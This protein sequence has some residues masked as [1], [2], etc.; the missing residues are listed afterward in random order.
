M[1]NLTIKDLSEK[2][3]AKEVSCFEVTQHF[4][5]RIKNLDKKINSFITVTEEIALNKAKELDNNFNI[6]SQNPLAGIPI[7]HKDLFATKGILTTSGSK[8][9]ANY[10]APYNATVVEKLN[11]A[12]MIMLGKLNMDEF[13]MGS[14]NETSYFGACLNP[15]NIEYVAGGSS[16]GSAAAVAMRLVPATTGT[17]TGGSIRLPASFCGVTGI[18]PTYGRVS[19]WGMTAFASSLDQAGIFANSAYDC[20]LLLEQIA[21]FDSKDSTSIN[22]PVPKYTKGINNSLN[23]ITIGLPKEFFNDSLD[24][25]VAKVLTESIESFKKLGVNF[26]EI[27]LPNNH[28]CIPA[29]YILAPAEAS[30]NLARY[31]GIRYGH[32]SKEYTN[33]EELIINSRHE[34][35]GDEVKRR[36]LTGTFVLSSGYYDAYYL[37]AKKIRELIKYDFDQAFTQVDAIFAPTSPSTA[38]K[39][40]E[41]YN[42]PVSMYLSDI[43]TIAV[44]LANLPAITAPAGFINDLPL[45]L[46]L[47]GNTFNEELLLNLTHK[48]QQETNHHLKLPYKE[49]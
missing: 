24:E 20:A 25:N 41:K 42:D 45:G 40:K 23:N 31:D 13:A 47:I 8:M 15:W 38:F 44:N 34:G 2:I 49:N 16:G 36:I 1:H 12:Q 22:T 14:S 43:F 6:I 29:Y 48:Y 18:K 17:D 26:K 32:R 28:L 27:S 37:K 10:K 7:A 3:A 21:G 46:Q 4:L 35:F 39:L 19:R 9:L 11:T 5:S 33:I 30:S